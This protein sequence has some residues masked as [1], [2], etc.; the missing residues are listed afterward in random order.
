RSVDDAQPATVNTTDIDDQH[1]D[2]YQYDDIGNLMKDDQEDIA[3]IEWTLYGK[4]KKVTRTATST[5]PDL[6]FAYDASGNR[7]AKIVKDKSPSAVPMATYYVRDASGNVMGIYE[8]SAGEPS[9]RENYVYGNR[10]I[11]VSVPNS[12]LINTVSIVSEHQLGRKEYELTDHLS[13]VRAVVSDL[14]LNGQGQV[15]SASDYYPFGSLARTYNPTG[16]RYGFNGHENDNETGWQDYGMRIYDPKLARFFRVDP[17]TKQY[18]WY[19]PYL[20]AGNMPIHCVDLDGLEPVE[21]SFYDANRRP[22]PLLSSTEWYTVRGKTEAESYHNAFM[23]NTQYG[24]T[25]AYKTIQ[26]RSDWYAHA[27][28]MV[29]ANGQSNYWFKAAQKVTAWWAVGAADQINLGLQFWP[30]KYLGMTDDAENLLRSANVYLLQENFK[31]FGP[32][33]LGKGPI[34]WVNTK[35]GLLETFKHLSGAELDN[36]MVVI[37]MTTLQNYLDEYKE[38]YIMQHGKEK[39]N[40]VHTNI[41]QLFSSQ[42]LNVSAQAFGADNAAS[43][44]AQAE[45]KK[46]YGEKVEFDFMNLEHRIFQGQKMAEYLRKNDTSAS[47][48]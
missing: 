17:I 45:F 4:V 14:S 24:E 26:S 40:S 16:T 41:N 36:Q 6:E 39:W 46:K 20:F 23:Y 48:N 30:G 31:N 29:N 37:E 8:Q 47:G 44:Y 2:N 3:T 28:K 1:S 21:V 22:R 5:K 10:R 13:N 25:Q 32:Y 43:N 34:K 27:H 11:G 19:S 35:T 33:V 12:A 9:I 42:L 7:V 18:P 38:K 15:V